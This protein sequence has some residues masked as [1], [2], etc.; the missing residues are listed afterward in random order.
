VP[1]DSIAIVAAPGLTSTQQHSLLIQHC[2]AASGTGA[3]YT[4]TRFAILDT[5]QDVTNGG[6]TPAWWAPYSSLIY[7]GN[8][9]YAFN[10]QAGQSY[11]AIYFPWIQV[12]DPLKP[13]S[14]GVFVPPSGHIAGIYAQ[15]DATRGVFKAPANVPVAGALALKYSISNTQQAYVNDWGVNCIR[16]LNGRILVW[17]A[18]TLGAGKSDFC[19]AMDA[20]FPYV[21]LRRLYLYIYSSILQGTQWAV[22]EPNN[23]LLWARIT[24]EVTEFLTTLWQQGALVGASTSQAFFV[25][26]DAETNPPEQEAKGAVVTLVGVA[27]TQPAEFVVFQV[28]LTLKALLSP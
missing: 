15:V 7:P 19:T 17:G 25:K 26:C 21:N 16:A 27:M 11:G 12:H 23:A 2:A 20:G 6:Q 3:A 5:P 4:G 8:A 24:R 13:S 28:S 22:F 10:T 1:I 18:R 14:A 9:D